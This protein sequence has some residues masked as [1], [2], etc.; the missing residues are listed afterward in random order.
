MEN[1]MLPR[2][3]PVELD[4]G[5]QAQS[6]ERSEAVAES[7]LALF[8]E[9]VVNVKRSGPDLPP[10]GTGQRGCSPTPMGEHKHVSRC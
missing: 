10:A 9:P 8:P 6:W 1:G 4:L 7:Q 3:T 5:A 2:E